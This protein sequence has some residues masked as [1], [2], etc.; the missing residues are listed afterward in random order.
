MGRALAEDIF[1]A[2]AS[3]LLAEIPDVL[4]LDETNRLLQIGRAHV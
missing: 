2:Y 1:V 4:E 3:P